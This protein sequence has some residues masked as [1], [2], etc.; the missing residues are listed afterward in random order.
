MPGAHCGTPA[1]EHLSEEVLDEPHLLRAHPSALSLS[2]SRH[3][4]T[5]VIKIILCCKCRTHVLTDD[6]LVA[7]DPSMAEVIAAR[8][9]SKGSKYLSA[10]K[11]LQ[12]S[13]KHLAGG[14][15]RLAAAGSGKSL[16][17]PS[18]PVIPLTVRHNAHSVAPTPS[19]PTLS[20]TPYA[21]SCT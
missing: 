12:G 4:C 5:D 19:P 2:P 14:P 15:T 17:L 18:A 20:R 6:Q 21:S 7:E 16:R 1:S 3:V 13:S 9:P 11:Q 10:S 8:S